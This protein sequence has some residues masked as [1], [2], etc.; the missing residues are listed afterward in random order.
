VALAGLA[1]AAAGLALA[2]WARRS[3]ADLWSPAVTVPAG[4]RLIERGPYARVRHP[5]YLGVFLLGT[6]SLLAHPS[7][8]ALCLWGGLT[9]GLALKAAQE[10]RLLAR[11]LG[12]R[13]QGYAAR[14][15]ALVPRRLTGRPR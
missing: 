5:L 12:A 13:W 10:E 7:L 8:A 1:L 4:G 3:L 14:V 15:P 2:L 11:A 6:G 9:L